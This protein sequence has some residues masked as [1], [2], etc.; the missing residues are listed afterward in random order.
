MLQPWCVDGSI[1]MEVVCKKE[2]DLWPL[3]VIIVVVIILPVVL[4]LVFYLKVRQARARPTLQ[5][6]W[7][8]G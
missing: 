1:E 8:V 7:L 4:M 5:H 6:G 2:A 3:Y